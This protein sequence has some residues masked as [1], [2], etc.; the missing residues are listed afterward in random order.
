MINLYL[1]ANEIDILWWLIEFFILIKQQRKPIY[2]TVMQLGKYKTEFL[3]K[4]CQALELRKL[5][6]LP[7]GFQPLTM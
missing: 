7:Q 3:L 1:A 4:N 6:I 5:G 2:F